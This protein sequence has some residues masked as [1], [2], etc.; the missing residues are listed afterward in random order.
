MT[1]E[2]ISNHT[3]QEHFK[4][5][6]NSWV[7]LDCSLNIR[8]FLIFCQFFRLM[9]RY[10]TLRRVNLVSNQNDLYIGKSLLS[11]RMDPFCGMIKG[12][13][14]GDIIYNHCSDCIAI[15]PELRILVHHGDSSELLLTSSVPYLGFNSTVA[16]KGDSFGCVLN[17]SLIHI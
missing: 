2:F 17:L 15:V 8:N 7:L 14:I 12:I 16:G 4:C 9:D 6:V 1:S 5:P 10:L 11:D 3:C 13:S